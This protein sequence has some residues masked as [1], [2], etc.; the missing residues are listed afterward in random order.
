M[1]EDELSRRNRLLEKFES[2]LQFMEAESRA[3]LNLARAEPQALPTT[4][5]KQ[6]R[7]R[8]VALEEWLW[9]NIE[10]PD[11]K[12]I[13]FLKFNFYCENIN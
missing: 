12:K 6:Q 9:G 3:Q 1:A 13:N 8:W 4:A 5:T 10:T 7:Q 11:L 2:M